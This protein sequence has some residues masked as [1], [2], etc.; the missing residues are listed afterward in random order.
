MKSM[1]TAPTLLN[2]HSFDVDTLLRFLGFW[3]LW[4]SE[5]VLENGNW[6]TKKCGLATCN[7]SSMAFERIGYSWI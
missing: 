6:L 2:D 5:R 4:H 1:K 3:F 7:F